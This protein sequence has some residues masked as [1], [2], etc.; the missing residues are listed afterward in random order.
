MAD[1]GR[2]RGALHRVHRSGRRRLRQPRR[3]AGKIRAFCEK[4][5]QTVPHDKGDI[6]RVATESLALKYRIVSNASKR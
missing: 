4:T 1:A 3:H 5:G 6:L 2:G